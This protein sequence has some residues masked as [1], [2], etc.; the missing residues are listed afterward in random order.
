MKRRVDRLLE[1]A[2]EKYGERLY[3]SAFLLLGNAHEAEDLCQNA[4][5]ELAKSIDRFEGRSSL[6]TWLHR[7]MLHLFY[8][9]LRDRSKRAT[10]REQALQDQPRFSEPSRA[11]EE[12]SGRDRAAILRANIQELPKIHQSVLVLKYFQGL[13]Y[14]EMSE[15]LDCP[16]GTVRSRLHKAKRELRRRME[17]VLQDEM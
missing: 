14:F 4:F 8:K 17:A 7:I 5:C 2:F 16:L 3:R 13:S 12:G 15:V 10:L 6:Y 1:R 11:L 9:E